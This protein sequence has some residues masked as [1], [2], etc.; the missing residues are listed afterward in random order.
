MR[1]RRVAVK[2]DE[3]AFGPAAD[4]DARAP[5]IDEEALTPERN[6]ETAGI[7]GNQAVELIVQLGDRERIVL[8]HDLVDDGSA[9]G[10]LEHGVEYRAHLRLELRGERRLRRLGRQN[11]LARRHS[12][13]IRGDV[14]RIAENVAVFDEHG[15]EMHANVYAD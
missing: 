1:S 6:G 9:A 5:L 15:S 11:L 8:P 3:I 12:R 14:D 13:E 7:A 10:A 2:R 4:V